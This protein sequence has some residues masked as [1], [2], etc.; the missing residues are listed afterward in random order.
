MQT[1][2]SGAERAVK[3]DTRN[4][5]KQKFNAE[6]LFQTER[7][8]GRE[9]AINT[10]ENNPKNRHCLRGLD[11]KHGRLDEILRDILN[12]KL[13]IVQN[14]KQA[15]SD[16]EDDDDDEEMP[17]ETGTPKIYDTSEQDGRYVPIRINAEEDAIRIHTG[18]EISS[19]NCEKR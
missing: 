18:G 8:T 9:P 10:C 6:P 14:K 19:E 16:T 13:K 5:M 4:I 12:G 2:V 17:E 3:T 1:A 7:K 15:I 11:G